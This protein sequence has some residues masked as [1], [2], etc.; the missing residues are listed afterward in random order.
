MK[1]IILV[2]FIF[3]A[4]LP[5]NSFSE[6]T[7]NVHSIIIF[8]MIA[9]THYAGEVHF[10]A[11]AYDKDG[12][13]LNNVDLTGCWSASSGMIGP[14]GRYIANVAGYHTITCAYEDVTSP[15]PIVTKGYASVHVWDETPR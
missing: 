9:Y 14:D 5:F 1:K 8:P 10:Q 2:I 3:S 6:T 15:D 4:L 12:N 7:P 13:R 11:T